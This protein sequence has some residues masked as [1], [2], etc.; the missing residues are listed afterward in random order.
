MNLGR[1]VITL[2]NIL[3]NY[4]TKKIYKNLFE[5]LRGNLTIFD[6][7]AHH[8]E[9]IKLLKL[10]VKKSV[11]YSFEIS[12]KNFLILKKNFFN[13]DGV[14]LYNFGFSD[15]IQDVKFFQA[16]E[17]SSTTLSKININS[18]YFKK[19]LKILGE[20]DSKIFYSEHIGSLTTID[21]FFEKNNLKKIDLLKIDTEGH[22]FKILLGAKK[23]LKDIKYIYF[24]HHYD[25]MIIKN[26]K[27]SDI[28]NYLLKN[29]F[30]KIH[31]Y[32]MLFRKTFEYIYKN[33]F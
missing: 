33:N 12:Q 21:N 27:F 18:N 10:F 4:K 15:K 26:Y 6:V 24:E 20:S 2:L 22:E 17:S 5:Q 32:K 19:K 23:T 9:S 16:K 1:L 7:G 31:K 14:Y 30:I 8:G 3:D 29:N 28:N 25:D 11:I 13:K